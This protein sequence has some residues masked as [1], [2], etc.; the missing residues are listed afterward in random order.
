MDFLKRTWCEIDLNCL[1][2]NINL[3]QRIAKKE[4]MA[5]V[6]ANAYGHGDRYVS[7]T[8]QE[9]GIHRF[10]VSNYNEAVNL[11]R[12]GITGS[13]LI[14]GY[15]PPECADEL[16]EHSITQTVHCLEY[17]RQ[18][19]ANATKGKVLVH[20]KADT[21]MSRIGFP[22]N[23]H[24]DSSEEILKLT[25]LPNLQICGLFTHFAC[26]DSFQ[27][28]DEAYTRKQMQALDTLA[29]ELRAHGVELECVHAQN[30]A[31]ITNYVNDGY[32]CARA[33]ISMY[34]L[35]PSA[36]VKGDVPI[37]P[38]LSLKTTVSMVKTIPAGTQVC[39]GRTFT[40][41]HEMQAATLTIGY[42]DG[43]Y[44]DFSNK[45]DV[46]IHGKRCRV[47]GRVC[48]DQIVVDVTGV[49]VQMGDTATVI[50]VDGEECITADELA[51]IA[52]TINYEI[53]CSISRRV[54]RVYYKDGKMID[55][56]DDS[57]Q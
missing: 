42:A 6:K 52:N 13:I 56:L 20:I 48:M 31:G 34:G 45:A 17:G 37:R 29:A 33:G 38:L 27:P 51:G 53:V 4:L 26:A 47:L 7:Q 15:T 5:V 3:L 40:A 35:N 1:Q 2:Y 24:C 16:I 54:P 49:E 25:K 36:D 57:V 44:R 43:Y 55:V 14:L 12:Y 22:Q 32:N 23:E 46:L 8:L 10:A 21:G 50:G 28:D 19:S 39:Y 9:A 30:S 18:L 41:P 11:R